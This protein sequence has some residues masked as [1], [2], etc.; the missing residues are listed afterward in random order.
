MKEIRRQGKAGKMGAVLTAVVLEGKGEKVYLAAD[1]SFVPQNLHKYSKLVEKWKPQQKL[2]GKSA[3]NVALYGLTR[4]G[5]LFTTRQLIALATF[6]EV[7]TSLQAKL[8]KEKSKAHADAICTYLAFVVDKCADY[9]SSVCSW[10]SARQ[11]MRN[12]FVRQ[13]IPMMWCYAEA[14]PFSMSSG[15][16][17]GM[18]KWLIKSSENTAQYWQRHCSTTR[19]SATKD[20]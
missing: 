8:N 14:Q 2:M 5:D 20:F 6:C 18:L 10:V 15:S 17:D 12:T 3:M 16:W 4:Y 7:L 11:T 13:A 9:W 1:E 19:R